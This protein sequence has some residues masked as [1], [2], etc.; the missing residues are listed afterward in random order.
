MNSKMNARVVGRRIPSIDAA[1][2]VTG[3]TIYIDDLPLQGLLVGKAL[4]SPH[5]HA[6]I[7]NVDTSRAERLSGVYAVLSR[8]N[9]PATK[10][11]INVK[12]E[13]AFC[14]E[15]VRYE[16]DEV[17][18]VA[19]IDEDTAREALA[20]IDVEYEILPAATDPFSALEGGAL[21]VH[22]SVARNIANQF[23]IRR[24]EIDEAFADAEAIFSDDFHTHLAH[25]A[26]IEP[27]GCVAQWHPNGQISL[28]GCLQSVF[29]I[30]TFLLSPVM[31]MPADDFRVTQTKPGGAFGGKL[32]VKAALMAAMLSQAAQKPVKFMLSLE[33]DL[34]SMRPR[35]PV[36]ISLESAWKKN[37]ALAGKRVKI[38]AEN[39]AYCSLSPAIMSSIALR[40]DNLYRTPAVEIEGKLVYTNA[41]PSGQMRGFGNVQATYAWESHL[42]NVADGLGIDPA[43]LRLKN[44]TEKGDV[45]LHGWKIESC[46]VAD[47]TNYVVNKIDWKAKRARGGKGRGVGLASCI[48]VSGNKGFSAALG[49]D[50]TDPSSGV[51]RIDEEG[52]V[53]IWSGES[54]LGQGATSVMAFIASEIMGIPVDHFSVPPTDTGY[55]PFGMGAFASRITLIGGNAIKIAAEDARK[56]LLEAAA[57]AMEIPASD[58]EIVEGEV[59][60]KSLPDRKM[61]V[62][63]VVRKAG[64]VIEGEGKWLAGGEVLDDQKYGNPS[65]TYSFSTHAAEVEVDMETGVVTV[66]KIYAGHD[67]GRVINRLGAEG[68]VEG[69]VI[70][71]MSYSMLE[72]LSPD[73]GHVRARNFHDYL[74]ATSMDAPR[75]EHDFFESMD[76]HGPFGAKGLAEVAIN[77]ITAAICNAIYHATGGAR[78]RTLPITPER[79]LEA[80]EEAG[81]KVGINLPIRR[82]TKTENK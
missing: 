28:W 13:T 10:F 79:V 37:G 55:M 26:Y 73:A 3:S 35:M 63:E 81:K 8:N 29:L 18:A 17:A 21:L 68:Q 43:E 57:E 67:P 36:H 82:K 70:Q 46:A 59:K 64:S 41:I 5:S 49:P 16:G 42:D 65:T 33:E 61:P 71:G 27:T 45:S 75:V 52:R 23:H 48:H 62:G 58:L 53:E 56:N 47:A 14:R 34:S 69:G 30:R 66:I 54:D 44:Y 76:P 9:T 60:A 15:K 2:K 6:R 72:G 22:D 24:G 31:G 40:T 78:I 77:P 51:V 32:D 80:I 19:A 4:R 25:Q 74:I 20:L 39:G 50:G 11:G 1:E 12:D 7:L 38:V